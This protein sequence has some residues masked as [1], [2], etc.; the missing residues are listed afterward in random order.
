MDKMKKAPAIVYLAVLCLLTVCVSSCS[1]GKVGKA[2]VSYS[3]I[4]VPDGLVGQNTNQILKGLGQ[5][6]FWVEDKNTQ[7]LGYSNQNGWY[8]YLM[9][10][11]FGKTDSTDLILEINNDKVNSAYLVDKGSSIGI[12]APPGAVAN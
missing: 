9:Y 12:F 3:D 6:D 5:P 2:N 8:L 1:F 10:L 7:Y 11:S 4:S